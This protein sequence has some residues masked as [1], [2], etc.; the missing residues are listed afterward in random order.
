MSPT[1]INLVQSSY[2]HHVIKPDSITTKLRVVFNGSAS[3][4]VRLFLN[5]VLKVG[6]KIQQDLFDIVARFWKYEYAFTAGIAK[7]YWQVLIDGNQL[8]LQ[9]ILWRNDPER[10]VSVY[11]VTFGTASAPFLAT[12]ALQ[13]LAED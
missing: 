5:S 3:S 10:D 7:V 12:R 1:S 11:A 2:D 9:L 4:S 8:H 6:A 13:Q